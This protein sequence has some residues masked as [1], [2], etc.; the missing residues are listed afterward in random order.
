[1]IA[2]S[3]DGEEQEEIARTSEANDFTAGEMAMEATC[4]SFAG[5]HGASYMERAGR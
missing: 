3:K 1:M 5:G 4:I 2:T